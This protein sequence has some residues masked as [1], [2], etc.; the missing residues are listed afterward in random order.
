MHG[1]DRKRFF[2]LRGASM[3]WIAVLLVGA[4]ALVGA[5]SALAAH[6]K[7]N[8]RFTGIVIGPEVNGF[9]PPVTF[10]VSA[11]GKTLTAFTYSTLGCFGEGGFQP[12]VDYYTRPD[13]FVKLGTVKVSRTGNFT[14]K[15]EV[16]VY[17]GVGGS[18]TTTSTVNG[19]FTSP[20]AVTGS[21]VFTQKLSPGGAKCSSTPLDFTA[22]T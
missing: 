5:A 21:L 4:V 13:A 12:G 19:S 15:G 6:P 10:K 7:R 1:T 14:V 17:K 20:T 16:S 2:G 11:N 22:K 8:A 3:R 9:K 18:T